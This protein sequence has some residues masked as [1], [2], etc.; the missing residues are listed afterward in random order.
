MAGSASQIF[1]IL[2]SRCND[3][4]LPQYHLHHVYGTVKGDRDGCAEARLLNHYRTSAHIEELDESIPKYVVAI[5]TIE[6]KIQ[7][8][9]L[10]ARAVN[11]A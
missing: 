8:I 6:P 11:I 2:T 7:N 1:M 9:I 5:I 4:R 10:P 3:P